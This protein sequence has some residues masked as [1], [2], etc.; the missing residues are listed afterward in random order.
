MLATLRHHLPALGSVAVRGLGVLA[1]IGTTFLIGRN[2]GP[3]ANGTY[4]LVTQTAIFL[5]VVA[6]GGL[7]M[8]VVRFFAA[9]LA[10]GNRIAV[11]SLWRTLALTL[12][13]TTAVIAATLL[14][15][16]VFGPD[17]LG[18]LPTAALPALI[19]LLA[20]RALIRAL[21]AVLRAHR[22]YLLGQAIDGLFIPAMIVTPLALGLLPDVEAAL[23]ATAAAG[24]LSVG[25]GFAAS[26]RA[27]RGPGRHAPVEHIPFRALLVASVPLWAL[28]LAQVIADWYGLATVAAQLGTHEAGLYRVAMQFASAFTIVSVSLYNVYSPQVSAAHA[29]GDWDEVARL[30]RSATRL[31][32]LLVLPP[33]LLLAL[34]TPWV[35]SFIG[36]EFVAASTAMRCAIVG[37]MLF[38]ALGPPGLV[39]AM[40][41][42]ERVMFVISLACMGTMLVLAP[43]AALHGGIVGVVLAISAVTVGRNLAEWVALHR[44]TGVNALTGAYKR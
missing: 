1:G 6:V 44:L 19:V 14:V 27:I 33:A 21:G 36:P 12:A 15:R 4:A 42:H 32:S 22:H 10:R 31:G 16:A 7:D 2:W 5:A 18:P 11:A 29:T 30:A 13:L 28:I 20:A 23:L 3:E 17:L 34:A 39:L 9:P 24:L 8:G 26:L 37:Q 41:G 35:L 38:V 25:I 43:L 40:V